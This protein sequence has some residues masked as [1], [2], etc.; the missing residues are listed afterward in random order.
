MEQNLERGMWRGKRL[1]DNQWIIGWPVKYPN[2]Y[3]PKMLVVTEKNGVK[4]WTW[5][6]VDP[7]TLGEYTGMQDKNG[8]PIFEGDIAQIDF[9]FDFNTRYV[10]NAER[11]D[12]A[13]DG[14]DSKA[15]KYV[16]VVA[17][18]PSAGVV[19]NSAMK[20]MDEDMT[21]TEYYEPPHKVNGVKVVASRTVRLGNRWDNPSLLGG[22]E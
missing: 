12:L 8:E 5:W 2:E 1:D 11:G 14:W 17:I 9:D 15:G 18:R 22:T 6:E 3:Y 19:L 16:G 21:T 10:G 13:V 20:T 4:T 7:S